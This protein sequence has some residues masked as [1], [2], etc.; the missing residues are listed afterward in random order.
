MRSLSLTLVSCLF[1]FSCGDDGPQE[2]VI[3]LRGAFDLEPGQESY[4]CYATTFDEA[5]DIR[6][7]E[8][9][10]T[11]GVHHMVVARTLAPEPEGMAECDVLFRNTWV[12]MFGSGTSEAEIDA[13]DG[14]AYHV[15]AG[16]Q[17]VMQLHLLNTTPDAISNE[18]VVR[19]FEAD[20]IVEL[21]PIGIYAFGTNQIELPPRMATDV[22]NECTVERDVEAF[23]IFPHMHYLGL[24]M[25]LEV[26]DD[27]GTWNEVFRKDGWDFDQQEFVP[28]L[29]QL[30][31]GTETRVTCSY[32][33]PTDEMVGFGE[34]SI[35][36]MCFLVTY[37]VGSGSNA[38]DGC[39]E[40][41]TGDPGPMCEP[42]ENEMG[43]GRACTEGGGE[44]AEGTTCTGDQPGNSGDGFCL[45]IGGCTMDADCGTGAVCC[46][47]AEAG[48]FL[49]ICLPEECRPSDCADPS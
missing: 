27:T 1:C 28:Q 22:V 49:N 43:I 11:L 48:G 14:A 24:S 41:G 36:E 39:V 35:D 15:S 13:P 10:A 7:F 12:P 8:V 4:L 6:R 3:E 17:V 33:N 18:I 21:E 38:L 47:P 2:G 20:P 9:D 26:R 46:A 44:C 42:T 23:A 31:P 34:S 37:V 30:T 32:D 45:R 25:S 40:L 29:L 19:A 16:E 5:V